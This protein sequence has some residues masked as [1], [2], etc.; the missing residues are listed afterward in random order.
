MIFKRF[1][2]LAF[3][4][5]APIALSGCLLLPGDFVADMTVK[6]SGE[7]SFTYKGEIQLVGLATLL[8]N[9]VESETAAEFAAT[10]YVD[11]NEEE[12]KK[13]KADAD[14]KAKRLAAASE[15]K[16]NA[17]AAKEAGLKDMK[18]E[19][20]STAASATA[21]E[22]YDEPPVTTQEEDAGSES[23]TAAVSDATTKAGDAAAEAGDVVEAAAAEAT[24]DSDL[25]ERDCTKDE[26]AEQK[27]EWD[28]EQALKVKRETEQKKLLT[29]F[30]GGIDPKDPKTINR[31]TKEVERLAAWNK[32]EH[33]GNGLFKIDYS[34]TGRLADDFAFPVIPRYSIGQPMIHITRW[35]NGRL[36]VEAPSFQND[37]DLSM[38]AMM[39]G[40]GL[41]NAMGGG[42]GGASKLPEPVEVKGTFTIRT[43][44][45]IIANNTD[46]GPID[47]AGM[48]V[49]RWE[50]GPKTYGAPMALLKLSK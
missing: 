21:Q 43:D 18:A 28:K 34:T 14:K 9:N 40:G 31:F 20:K 49:M 12:D 6:K 46:E 5:S 1:A 30:L 42:G 2:A 26:I 3:A 25:E 22:D 17:D 4:V 36:R 50:I 44:A 7:F 39:G 45:S 47:E 15:R 33:L 8:N 27:A 24:S 23:A 29:M 10:C 32:V 48:Q 16:A 19:G 41:M 13:T 38:V 11:P 35:D 37:A